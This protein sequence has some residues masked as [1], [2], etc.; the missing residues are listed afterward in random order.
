MLAGRQDV[1]STAAAPQALATT[2]EH[3]APFCLNTKRVRGLPG[4]HNVGKTTFARYLFCNLL[5]ISFC[6][7]SITISNIQNPS[8][9]R[10]GMGMTLNWAIDG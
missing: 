10:P 6:Y 3:T 7:N 4:K 1:T 9:F 8:P 2:S 5:Q